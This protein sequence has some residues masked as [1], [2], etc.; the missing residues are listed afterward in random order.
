MPN[1]T[2][3]CYLLSLLF[4]GIGYSKT[5]V[6]M[7]ALTVNTYD[8]TIDVSLATAYF[9]LAIFLAVIG[10]LFF[11]VKNNR[12]KGIIEIENIECSKKVDRKSNDGKR[13]SKLEVKAQLT[14]SEY[15]LDSDRMM[16]SL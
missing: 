8:N 3:I 7:S 11:Y 14:Q 9:V 6:I 15:D 1:V 2:A 16:S 12:E 4:Y 13:A 10:S 5:L